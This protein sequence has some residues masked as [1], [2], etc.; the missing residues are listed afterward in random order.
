MLFLSVEVSYF[1]ILHQNYNSILFQ[2]WGFSVYSFYLSSYIHAYTW[3]I[4]AVKTVII[5][6]CLFINNHTY[7][8]IWPFLPILTLNLS[9]VCGGGLVDYSCLWY[10][11]SSWRHLSVEPFHHQNYTPGHY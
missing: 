5:S 9:L 1:T 11:T 4:L 3:Y 6:V 2:V 7:W 8:E 10:Y